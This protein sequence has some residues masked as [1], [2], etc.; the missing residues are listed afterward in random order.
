MLAIETL[1]LRRNTECL[2]QALQHGAVRGEGGRGHGSSR[3]CPVPQPPS[4]YPRDKLWMRL[5]RCVVEDSGDR[6]LSSLGHSVQKRWRQAFDK[7]DVRIAKSTGSV[8]GESGGQ[9]S[10]HGRREGGDSA[11]FQGAVIPPCVGARS[12]TQP[13]SLMQAFCTRVWQMFGTLCPDHSLRRQ[14]TDWQMPLS[15]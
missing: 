6:K 12:T 14:G 15:G 1:I 10:G 9:L 3:A 13:R 8:T 5:S 11:V 2:D 7:H 4:F